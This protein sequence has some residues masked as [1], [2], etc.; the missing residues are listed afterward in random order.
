MRS[1]DLKPQHTAHRRF[2]FFFSFNSAFLFYFKN[3]LADRIFNSA[4]IFPFQQ[5]AIHVQFPQQVFLDINSSPAIAD[6][7]QHKI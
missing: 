1:C 7:G 5:Q 2:F 3:R 4:S 6:Q